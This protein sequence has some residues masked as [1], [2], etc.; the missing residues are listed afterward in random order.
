MQFDTKEKKLRHNEI[1]IRKELDL[2]E[3]WVND[4]TEFEDFWSKNQ[5]KL[6]ILSSVVR[7]TNIIPAT[8][9]ASESAFSIAGYVNRKERSGLS[10]KNLR[11]SMLLRD[12]NRINLLLNN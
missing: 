6:P 2:Y 1:G 5:N 3:L 8:S 7:K 10:S 12:E 4:K 9:V 11:Y